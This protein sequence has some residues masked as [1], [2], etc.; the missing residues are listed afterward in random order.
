MY[1]CE[2]I[3]QNKS[4]MKRKHPGI[5]GSVLALPLVSGDH[6]GII[7]WLFLLAAVPW[8]AEPARHSDFAQSLKSSA[9]PQKSALAWARKKQTWQI[10][11]LSGP[12]Y[13][14]SLCWE[15]DEHT[16]K[17]CP[18]LCTGERATAVIKF[19]AE[20]GCQHKRWEVLLPNLI[21]E[22]ECVLKLFYPTS[23]ILLASGWNVLSEER[24]GTCFLCVPA[25]HNCAKALP[26]QLSGWG[27]SLRIKG[28]RR[29]ENVCDSW[30]HHSTYLL[31]TRPLEAMAAAC[32]FSN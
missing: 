23:Q 12:G 16:Q 32:I 15:H 1:S 27:F 19:T 21:Q 31:E 5:W 14:T 28:G 10:P 25:A 26:H 17:C 3:S 22:A 4:V 20:W 13:G 30:N 8:R 6:Q 9:A 18:P 24:G 7:R 29:G 11:Q 2:C